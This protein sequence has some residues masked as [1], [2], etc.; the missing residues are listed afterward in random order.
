MTVFTHWTSDLGEKFGKEPFV[1][2]HNLHERDMFT[3]EGIASLLDRYPRHLMN[4]YTMNDDP[5][6]AGRIFRR[7]DAGDR[8]SLASPS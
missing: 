7:G 1:T 5:S 2:K 3:D 4:L 6:N 8:R